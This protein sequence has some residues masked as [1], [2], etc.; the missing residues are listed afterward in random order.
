M[1]E[2][3]SFSCRPYMSIIAGLGGGVYTEGTLF[4]LKPVL[5]ARPSSLCERIMQLQEEQLCFAN[6]SLLCEKSGHDFGLILKNVRLLVAK[7]Q[8]CLCV[9]TCLCVC[10][11]TPVC[12]NPT[13]TERWQ[14]EEEE[15]HRYT[16]YSHWAWRG[17][18]WGREA[19]RTAWQHNH[20]KRHSLQ[21]A[22]VQLSSL[23]AAA[24]EAP[25][26]SHAQPLQITTSLHYQ[27]SSQSKFTFT[28][29]SLDIS[30][31]TQ[32]NWAGLK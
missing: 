6:N 21:T 22:S 14:E 15:W 8:L 19:L 12:T 18:R 17:R 24:A 1:D 29:S 3:I 2:N 16:G 26:S 13:T 9:C 20:I 30:G 27:S 10:E 7:Q 11:Y 5:L 28:V 25:C 4:L 32:S 31:F 23:T